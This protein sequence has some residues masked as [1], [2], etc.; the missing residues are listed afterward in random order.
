MD[1]MF[2]SQE[3]DVARAVLDNMHTHIH[4]LD[5]GILVSRYQIQ[6]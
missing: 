4:I 5:T 6:H 3:I 1:G 2:G